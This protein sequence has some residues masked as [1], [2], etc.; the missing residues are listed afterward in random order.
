M[1]RRHYSI[2][3]LAGK[4]TPILCRQR[5]LLQVAQFVAADNL[6]PTPSFELPSILPLRVVRTV[7]SGD[8]FTVGAAESAVLYGSL[9]I[10][11]GGTVEVDDTG[12]LEIAADS[13]QTVPAWAGVFAVLIRIQDGYASVTDEPRNGVYVDISLSAS[14]DYIFSAYLRGGTGT[15]RITVRT[16]SN[17][18]LASQT[19]AASASWQ[20]VILSFT[21]SGAG[22]YRL[23]MEADDTSTSDLITDAWML[24]TVSTEYGDGSFAGWEWNGTPNNSTSSRVTGPGGV[25]VDMAD[26]NLIITGLISHLVPVIEPI[27]HEYG[28]LPGA[29]YARERVASRALTLAGRLQGETWLHL[30]TLRAELWEIF[31]PSNRTQ[32][33][34]T[35]LRY[36]P[37]ADTAQAVE[38]DV[39]YQSGLQGDSENDYGEDIALDLLALAP[40]WRG[41]EQ[42]S[43]VLANGANTVTYQGT[44]PAPLMITFTGVGS[45]TSIVVGSATITSTK[46]LA[47]GDYYQIDT[48]ALTVELNG[49]D[50]RDTITVSSDLIGA[51][52]ETGDNTVTLTAAAGVTCTLAWYERYLTAVGRDT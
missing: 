7:E 38:L 13:E 6:I 36:Q 52:L 40:Y 3:E 37:N 15:H 17:T 20:R 46:T 29:Y 48:G 21:T 33:S 27:R 24:S 4:N 22:T 25:F 9:E 10:E 42:Q 43:Q 12:S 18:I 1:T 16:T 51:E 23:F 31:N 44:A 2:P 39:I 14:T 45:I 35:T 30:Q 32:P 47:S 34:L 50:A 28:G 5:G 41:V 49:A 19:I 8:T 11:D 26:R